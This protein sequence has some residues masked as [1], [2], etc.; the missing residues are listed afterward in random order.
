MTPHFSAARGESR[1]DKLP[2]TRHKTGDTNPAL[3]KV[4]T[5]LQKEGWEITEQPDNL[6][7]ACTEGAH[8]IEKK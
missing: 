3:E 2:D 8:G 7:P 6:G 4:V 1:I 5:K